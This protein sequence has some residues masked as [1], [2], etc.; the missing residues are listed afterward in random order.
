MRLS[1]GD[2]PRLLRC[3]V[4]KNDVGKNEFARTG[5]LL[6]RSQAVRGGGGEWRR[7]VGRMYSERALEVGFAMCAACVAD[8][9]PG[10]FEGSRHVI[11]GVAFER[12]RR[13]QLA[14]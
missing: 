6:R 14:R 9:I 7:C 2:P 13:A 4:G 8:E 10:S 11:S 1:F 3:R 5:L 12:D